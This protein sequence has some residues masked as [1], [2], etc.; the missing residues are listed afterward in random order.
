[1]NL[2]SLLCTVHVYPDHWSFDYAASMSWV[3]EHIQD[4][5]DIVGKPVIHEEFGKYRDTSPPVQRPPAPA[6][7]PRGRA[8][9]D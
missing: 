3:E 7:V 8:R 2:K 6:R 4:A 1:M 5:H 9:P